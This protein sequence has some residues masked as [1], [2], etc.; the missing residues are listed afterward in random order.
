MK[1]I[2]RA[3]IQATAFLAFADDDVIE[4]DAAV[5][6]LEDIGH[7]LHDCTTE[8]IAILRTVLTEERAQAAQLYTHQEVLAFYDSFLS[9]FGLRDRA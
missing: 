7:F 8:E 6:A 3:L 4:P 5:R 1:A 9:N 2:A